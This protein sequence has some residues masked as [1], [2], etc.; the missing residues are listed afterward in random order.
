MSWQNTA[1]I[2]Q[3]LEFSDVNSPHST[4]TWGS[5]RLTAVLLIPHGDKTPSSPKLIHTQWRDYVLEPVQRDVGSL[6]SNALMCDVENPLTQGYEAALKRRLA[7][8]RFQGLSPQHVIP[9]RARKLGPYKTLALT[10]ASP[11]DLLTSG[12]SLEQNPTDA[13]V[14]VF[15]GGGSTKGTPAERAGPELRFSEAS[16]TR[17]ELQ[18]L[19]TDLG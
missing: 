5:A 8:F 10:V 14:G 16:G 9:C 1:D 18:F 2:G 3:G 11:W 4:Q 6:R 13:C 12:K 17:S 7:A 15:E 19:S